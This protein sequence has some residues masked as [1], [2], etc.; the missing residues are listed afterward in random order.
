MATHLGVRSETEEALDAV[1]E[2]LRTMPA[3]VVRNRETL[4]GLVRGRVDWRRTAN[5]R[6]NAGDGTLF[7]CEPVDRRYDTPLGR[8]IKLALVDVE[9]LYRISGFRHMV[10][11]KR[12]DPDTIGERLRM[13]SN[14]AMRLL[15]ASK[16]RQVR[17]VDVSTLRHL[18]DTVRR[19]PKA[20]YLAEL[21]RLSHS[22]LVARDVAV[23]R[24]LLEDTVFVP[25]APS[26]LFELQ[27]GLEFVRSL[28]D[29]GFELSEPCALLPGAG[30]PFAVLR[31]ESDHVK[32]WWQRNVWESLASPPEVGMWRR[33]LEA[34]AI[35]WPTSLLPDFVV[36]FPSQDRLVLIEV[37]LTERKG[38][39]R[40]RD[41]IR[42]L[43]TY[44]H[45]VGGQLGDTKIHGVVI[46]WNATG[47]PVSPQQEIQV[48]SQ[49]S[50]GHVF[51]DLIRE[52]L[53]K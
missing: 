47:Y 21:A 39:N 9:A 49:R 8:L 14:R 6:V 36:E 12:P 17:S 37:K 44:L 3:S 23:L 10:D 25:K 22:G 35:D 27:V 53:R 50:A 4:S 38:A 41:G 46:A 30:A 18:D 2:L 43:F 29:Y 26:A 24:E 52:I 45:D 42:D 51:S 19:H 32:V 31:L 5:A 1:E 48:T 7:V 28:E 40:E 34:N 33:T 15:R 13:T 16:L 11:R 20:K